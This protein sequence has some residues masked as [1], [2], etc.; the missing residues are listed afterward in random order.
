MTLKKFSIAKIQEATQ[1]QDDNPLQFIP[2][3]IFQTYA[4]TELTEGAYHAIQSWRDLNPTW[5]HYF[6]TDEDQRQ[7]IK[8]NFSQEVLWSYDQLIPGAYKADLWR[9]C[10]LYTKG[11]IYVDHKLEINIALDKAL[12]ENVEFATYQ[13]QVIKRHR[14]EPYQFYLWQAIIISKPHHPFLKKAI[15]NIVANTTSGN[16]GHDTLSITGPGLLGQSVNEVLKRPFNTSFQTGLNQSS[17]FNF[18]IMPNPFVYKKRQPHVALFNYESAIRMY[19]SY[20]QERKE[21]TIQAQNLEILDYA[22]A[23]F[24]NKVYKHGKC[25]RNPDFSHF[26]RKLPRF[27]RRKAKHAFQNN[28]NEFAH[29]LVIETLTRNPLQPKVW[30]LWLKYE[31]FKKHFSF[32]NIS[33]SK[34]QNKP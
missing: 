16:Y 19:P 25:L 28:K 31:F 32:K 10:V 30:W 7:F 20:Y 21:M 13:D 26:K 29:Q 27:Y 33:L 23:W 8:D 24:F 3:N 14:A 34:F 18:Y 6:F 4:S 17:G 22:S 1:S 12:P 5:S 15:D 11:G 9:Y 2:K